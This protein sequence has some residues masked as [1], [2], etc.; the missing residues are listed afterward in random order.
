[1]IFK[2]G[3]EKEIFTNPRIK[4]LHLQNILCKDAIFTTLFE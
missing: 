2:C 1:M 4:E 3:K